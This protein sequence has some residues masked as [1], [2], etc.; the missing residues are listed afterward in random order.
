MDLEALKT[1][2]VC[3]LVSSQSEYTRWYNFNQRFKNMLFIAGVTTGVGTLLAAALADGPT[4]KLW[5][6]VFGAASTVAAALTR[7]LKAGTKAEFYGGHVKE[8]HVLALK[9]PLVKTE[10]ELLAIV[11]KYAAILL[12]EGKLSRDEDS[13]KALQDVLAEL[14]K[15]LKND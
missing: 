11:E 6:A 15:K 1:H 8:L 2:Y 9:I 5:A 3:D 10:Q 14:K 12:S 7:F 4:L 13:G